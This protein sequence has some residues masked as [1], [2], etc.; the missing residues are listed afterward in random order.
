MPVRHGVLL[1]DKPPGL[2]SHDAVA[3]VRKRFATKAVGHT[4][5]LDPFATGL[6]VLVLGSA[7]RLARWGARR[8]KTYR[9]VARLGQSTTTDDLTGPVVEERRPALW[10]DIDTVEETMRR[11][12][13]EIEQRPP[14]FSAKRVGGVRS[15]HAARTTG[16]VP[17]LVPVPVTV[18][19]IELLEWAPPLLT[20]RAEV[21]AGTYLRALARDLGESL[22]LGAHLVELRRERVGPWLVEEAHRLDDLTGSEPLTPPE[23]LVGDLARIDL[24]EAEARAVSHGRDIDRAG[25]AALDATEAGLYVEGRLVA[26]GERRGGAWHPTVVL[27]D[28]QEAVR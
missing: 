16:A 19:R 21:G 12:L 2:S 9:A 5:T 1:V 24:T 8:P 6:L 25:E 3:R 28:A 15:Y 10:P 17:P 7:T 13:G 23:I 22:A 4:G 26:I 18:Y 20:F 11:F 27:R 14:D